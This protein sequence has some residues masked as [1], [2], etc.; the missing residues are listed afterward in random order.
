MW[1]SPLSGQRTRTRAASTIKS[2]FNC[3]AVITAVYCSNSK[4]EL[5]HAG[6]SSGH[7]K[8][9]TAGRES[10]QEQ[11]GQAAAVTPPEGQHPHLRGRERRQ[12]SPRQPVAGGG[13]S[14]P[15]FPSPGVLRESGW[16]R[17][18][19]RTTCPGATSPLLACP[20]PG[21]A[22]QLG[23]RWQ[24]P[25]QG[26]VGE[27]PR[28]A[29]KGR[30]PP[31]PP[32]LL[33]DSP[34][35]RPGSVG[36]VRFL[37]VPAAAAEVMAAWCGGWWD[38]QGRGHRGC[39]GCQRCQGCWGQG[40]TRLPVPA[41]TRSATLGS[42]TTSA[43][44]GPARGQRNPGRAGSCSLR[45]P[46]QGPRDSRSPGSPAPAALPWAEVPCALP[47]GSPW[48]PETPTLWGPGAAASASA[49]QDPWQ[50]ATALPSAGGCR[51]PFQSNGVWAE[52]SRELPHVQL[53]S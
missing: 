29:H 20:L 21:L 39:S 17:P 7:E 38:R 14:R 32:P 35:A 47:R 1:T 34:G 16:A 41:A 53:H 23:W 49:V 19:P 24:S 48:P 2:C 18:G 43:G 36:G 51:D 12:L 46:G 4:G 27:G 31:P 28:P 22:L 3:G 37:L 50:A 52:R 10:H 26:P 30:G 9:S 13:G 15:E 11:K 6:I 42:S 44:G 8:T 25:P 45:P 33:G 5:A 40:G